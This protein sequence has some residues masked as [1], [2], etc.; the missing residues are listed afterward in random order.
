MRVRARARRAATAALA[1]LL[2]AAGAACHA[3]A[4][5]AGP[6]RG[7]VDS[8]NVGYGAQARGTV[9]G[10]VASL[11]SADIDAQRVVF[12]E[13]LLLGRLP[14]VEV[15]RTS[16]GVRVR[17]RGA[18]S[19]HGPTDPLFVVDGMPLRWGIDNPLAGINPGDV[20]RIDVLKDAAASIYGSQ[21]ANG[22][23]LVTTKRRR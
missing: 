20:A 21:G 9:A 13:E 6:A 19:F 17:I 7:P 18:T 22:V 5:Q 16:G 14:G 10:A 1:T 11:D 12:V 3:R 15:R 4:G 2:T 23:I 8:V